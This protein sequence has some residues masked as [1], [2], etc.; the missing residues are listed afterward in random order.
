MQSHQAK[1]LLPGPQYGGRPTLL[2]DCG[3]GRHQWYV[4]LFACLHKHTVDLGCCPICEGWPSRGLAQSWICQGDTHFPFPSWLGGDVNRCRILPTQYP[5]SVGANDPTRRLNS[6][7]HLRAKP[8]NLSH[9]PQIDNMNVSHCF[10]LNENLSPVAIETTIFSIICCACVTLYTVHAV[11]AC[12]NTCPQ[13]HYDSHFNS[14]KATTQYKKRVERY[15]IENK[16]L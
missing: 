6:K 9:S 14:G 5:G 11:C 3:A 8:K 12:H 16:T 7:R 13:H 4:P 2:S 15:H 10:S 1:Q